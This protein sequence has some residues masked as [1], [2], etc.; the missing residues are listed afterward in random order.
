MPAFISVCVVGVL[1][2]A[3]D[4]AP[5]LPDTPACKECGYDLRGS[6]SGVCPECGASVAGKAIS[7]G[8]AEGAEEVAS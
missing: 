7:R 2:G 1:C 4:Q 6:V 5:E 8:G 3:L